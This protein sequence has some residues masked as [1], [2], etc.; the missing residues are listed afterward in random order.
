MKLKKVAIGLAALTI[1]L[2]APGAAHAQAKITGGP[3][4]NVPASGGSITLQISSF[5][6]KGG[7]Y[8]Q[9]CIAPIGMNRPTDCNKAAELWIS[10]QR[11]ASF[12]PSA[13]IEF[14]PT[15]TF[16]GAT[17]EVD[18]TK[19]SCGI[20]ARYDHTVSGDFSEDQ[21]IAL[22]FASSTGA[23]ALASDE[24]TATLGGKAL[25]SRNPLTIAY[26]SPL[27]FEAKSKA[28]AALSYQSFAPACTLVD[29]VV[30]ALKASGLCDI[31]VTSAGNA[32]ASPIT[33]H[34][35]LTLT[36]GKD[37]LPVIA[38]SIKVGAKMSLPATS[39]FGEKVTYTSTNKNCTLS[40][41][42]L[43][44]KKQGACAIKAS[45]KGV[46]DLYSGIAQTI[47]INVKK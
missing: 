9:Q 13:T 42:T 45:S 11:G 17:Q 36:T 32:T 14:K 47:A 31:A 39:T 26:R 23:P 6:T 40:G 18:C 15:A 46:A 30:T 37:S 22:T 5:P 12:A 3:L 27:K 8:I 4:T 1:S 43:M 44:A 24:I 16:K 28:G 10:D 20:Y 33:V 19:V 34:F 38:K 25:D 29:G 21:F 2:I 41:A 35:P 7:L